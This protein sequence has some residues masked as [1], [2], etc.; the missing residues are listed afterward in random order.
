M[1][2]AAAYGLGSIPFGLLTARLF[3]NRRLTEQGSG[4]IGSAN[5]LRTT[6]FAAALCTLVLDASKGA[7]ATL[8]ATADWQLPAVAAVVLG[9][10]YPPWRRGGKG[11]AVCLG[12][13]AALAPMFALAAAAFWL[14]IALIGNYASIASLAAAALVVAL[15][16]FG[17]GYQPQLHTATASLMCGLIFWGHRQNIRRLVCGEELPLRGKKEEQK[18]GDSGW[19][20][21]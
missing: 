12:V 16:Y 5:V 19:G 18:A 11:V 7:A 17:G 15:S 8:I 10:M 4:N 2:V 13:T 3:G 14:V 6:G 20:G 1:V 9:H 21:K